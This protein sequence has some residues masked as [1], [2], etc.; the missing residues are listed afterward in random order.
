M[1]DNP[2]F[3]PVLNFLRGIASLGVC[4][5]HIHY[6]CGLT[7]Y[8]LF[9]KIV[10]MGQQGVPIFFVISGFVIPYSLYNSKY[11]LKDFFKYILKRS[12]RIDP[13]YLI[14][15]LLCFIL[16][17][18]GNK[19]NISEFILHFFYLIPFSKYEWYNGVYWT[20]GIEFQY[21][22]LIGL[23]F[24]FLKDGNVKVVIIVLLLLSIIGYNIPTGLLFN[25]KNDAYI[26]MHL[27]YFCMGIVVFL[28]KIDRLKL[29][30]T[31]FIPMSFS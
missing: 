28:F 10:T 14:S 4:A 12:L 17:Q 1:R 6:A 5:I 7:K 30:D 11:E 25:K 22:I 8:H 21:Y 2:K 23:A 26:T 18:I 27:H 19:F 13:P 15:I 20:L 9:S 29:R 16:W 24:K 3:I 31:H